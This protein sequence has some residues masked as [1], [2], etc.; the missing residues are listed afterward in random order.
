[1]VS[2]NV[3]EKQAQTRRSFSMKYKRQALNAINDMMLDGHTI[4]STSNALNLPHWYYM[5]WRKLVAKI[6]QI[7]STDA[8]VPSGITGDTQKVHPGHLSQLAPFQGELLTSVFEMRQQGLPINMRTLRKEAA[9]VS[10]K[11]KGKSTQAKISNVYHFI[12]KVGLSNHVSTH[13]AQKDHRETEEE[14]SH[15]LTLMRQKVAGMG[16]EDILNMDQTQI[17]YSVPSN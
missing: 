2:V 11:F 1:M 12:K 4:R 9:R 16:P 15:F 17:P 10:D 13:V 8:V 5:R 14:Y 7:A 6:D 3:V